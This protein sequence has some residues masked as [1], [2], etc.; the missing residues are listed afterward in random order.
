MNIICALV[1]AVVQSKKDY[2]YFLCTQEKQNKF[3]IECLTQ[4]RKKPLSYEFVKQENEHTHT[5][6]ERYIRKEKKRSNRFNKKKI[7][8]TDL[9]NKD[10]Q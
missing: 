4:K 2:T 7:T 3:K 6:K 1:V 5:H 8:H 10:I 9:T